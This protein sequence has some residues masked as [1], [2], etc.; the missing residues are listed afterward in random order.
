MVEAGDSC[1]HFGGCLRAEP[2]LVAVEDSG[3]GGKLLSCCSI[4]SA[5]VGELGGNLLLGGEF[6]SCFIG[7][8]AFGRLCADG[9]VAC[10]TAE[11]G[12]DGPL[13]V[14]CREVR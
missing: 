2:G 3:D 11:V 8:D 1:S 12:G 9:L 4:L 10:L 13:E 6:G 5:G 7:G 14:D